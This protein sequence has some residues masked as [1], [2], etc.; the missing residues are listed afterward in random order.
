MRR[1]AAV[2][3]VLVVLGVLGGGCGDDDAATTTAAPST[4]AATTTTAAP[5]TTEA[6]TTTA[7]PTT[8][9]A[10][11][12]TT[13]T[14]AA[15]TDT[16]PA[17]PYSWSAGIP[18][19]GATA[20]YRVTTYGGATLDLPATIER[21]V[22]WKGGIW[23]RFVIGTPEGGNDAA[24]IYMDLSDPWVVVLKGAETY[25]AGTAGGPEMVEWFEDP[26]VFDVNLLP[27]TPVEVETEITLEFAGGGGMTQGA[28]YRLEVV[29]R[30]EDV[31]VPAGTLGPTVQLRATIGG[32]FM[33]GGTFSLDLWMHP[34]QYLVKMN[35]GPA[36][37]GIELLS[38]W[39]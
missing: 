4:T 27:D 28:T 18:A 33:G 23:D 10:P 35:D 24:A 11:T 15:P 31:T 19:E 36:F 38:P 14:T 20:T 16:H 37:A 5:T 34:E 13:T 9:E 2:S 25:T 29:T 39:A 26:L 30:G 8:T 12:T 21:G 17:V 22:E 7:A 32:A 3:V 6:P 1:L